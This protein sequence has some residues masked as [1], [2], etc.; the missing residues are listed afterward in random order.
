MPNLLHRGVNDEPATKKNDDTVEIERPF[1]PPPFRERQKRVLKL[2]DEIDQHEEENDPQPDRDPDS[3]LS[4]AALLTLRSP[5]GLQ[6]DVEEIV[7]PE[8]SLQQNQQ[9]QRD[10]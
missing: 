10:K 1:N 3:Q 6:G 7:E 4:D 5:L 8:N 9:T 2:F